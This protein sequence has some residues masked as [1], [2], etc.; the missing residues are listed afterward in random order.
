[1]SDHVRART[2]IAAFQ[3]NKTTSVLESVFSHEVCVRVLKAEFILKIYVQELLNV[4]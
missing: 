3:Y 4:K 2:L 1:M